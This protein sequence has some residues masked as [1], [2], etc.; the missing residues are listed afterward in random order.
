MERKKGFSRPLL[1]D[2]IVGRLVSRHID[3]G[4]QCK[5]LTWHL[6]LIYIAVIVFFVACIIGYTSNLAIDTLI[7]KAV[8]SGCLTGLTSFV[9]VRMLVKYVPENIGMVDSKDGEDSD[10][11]SNDDDAV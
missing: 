9:L 3:T 2:Q 11:T 10:K 1:L 6:L 5:P 4:N 7:Q 8:I